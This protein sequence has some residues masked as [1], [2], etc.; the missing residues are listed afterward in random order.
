M[1]FWMYSKNA[2]NAKMNMPKTS[3]YALCLVPE[4]GTKTYEMLDK[5]IRDIATQYNTPV[6][7]AHVTLLG[8]IEGDAQDIREKTRM[9]AASLEPFEIQPGGIG[10]NGIYF[11]VL[12]SRV[13]QT[14]PVMNA[15][16]LAQKIFAVERGTYFP[17]LSLAY[18]DLSSD[19]VATLQ[20]FVGQKIS[21]TGMHFRA[22]G[23]ELWHTE[24]SIEEWRNIA[25]F[26]FGKA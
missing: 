23:V 15:N 9:L 11:Q 18:G 3:G 12:F 1:R 2:A 17:H 25:F 5:L 21:L 4:R 8:G 16:A 19:Q 24:G 20:E 6:F 14:L 26:P 10:S 13:E 7:D 22:K